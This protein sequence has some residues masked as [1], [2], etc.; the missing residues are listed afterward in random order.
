MGLHDRI[1]EAVYDGTGRLP[2]L[3]IRDCIVTRS[4][5]ALLCL[6]QLAREDFDFGLSLNMR[7]NAFAALGLL[8][9]GPLGLARLRWLFETEDRLRVIIVRLL[10]AVAADELDDYVD[11]YGRASDF[12]FDKYNDPVAS[13][14]AAASSSIQDW[15]IDCHA[16]L[17]DLF[18]SVGDESEAARL[19]SMLSSAGPARP[20]EGSAR[21]LM[22]TASAWRQAISAYDIE[23]LQA[24]IVSEPHNEPAFQRFFAQHPHLLDP[25]VS[26]GLQP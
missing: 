26:N 25:M 1:H 5:E 7:F 4:D 17:L 19:L 14:Y 22:R 21:M 18:A 24:A 3:L 11:A 6:T 20:S 9:W 15:R 23:R 16:L 8:A 13:I 2:D 10:A 12:E